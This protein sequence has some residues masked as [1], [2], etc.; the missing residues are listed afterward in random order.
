MMEIETLHT[1]DTQYSADSVEWCPL[2][3][4]ANCFVVGTYQLEEKDDA[5][6]SN[7]IRVGRIYLF[8]Y[9]DDCN[10]LTECQRI[11]TDA[12]LDQK[13]NENLLLAATSLG[14]IQTYKLIENRLEEFQLPISLCSNESES[15]L[16][17]SVEIIPK[18]SKAI[19]SDSKGRVTLVDIDSTQPI[20]SSGKLM[21]LK[22]GRALLIVIAMK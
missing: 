4:H 7:N 19:A 21:I 17:L 10:V 5:V 18:T 16:A 6:S 15:C 9:D 1:F 20:L 12:I 14:N 3:Q 2:E 11:E 22:H 13:W 8:N